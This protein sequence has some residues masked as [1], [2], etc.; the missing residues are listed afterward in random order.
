MNKNIVKHIFWIVIG[1]M[2]CFISACNNDSVSE[3]Q[4]ESFL[5]YYA[6]GIDDNTGTEVIQTPGGYAILG[7]Y[8]NDDDQKDLFVIFTDEFGR[9]KTD[10]PVVIGTD[11][12]DHGYSMISVNDG[13]LITGTSFDATRKLGYLVM[14][15]S[16]GRRVLWERNYSGYQELVFRNAC[17]ARD[18]NLIITGYS[19]NDT[20]DREVILF[21]TSAELDSMWLKLYPLPGRNDVGEAIIEHLGR[22]HILTTSTLVSS[23]R[24]SR[25]RILNTSTDGRGPWQ[26]PLLTDYLS[27]KDIAINDAGNMYILGNLED[28][29]SRVSKI[30]LA[31]LVLT[32][33]NNGITNLGDSA[34]IPDLESLHAAS[35]AAV[36]QNR[37]AI[38]GTQDKQSDHNILYMLVD[39]DNDF[40]PLIRET[41]GSNKGYQS[42]ESIIYTSDQGFA[43]TGSIDLAD[44]KTSML[45][46][47]DSDGELR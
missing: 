12:K 16:D 38:G 34:T 22:Y 10:S 5:K 30:F 33:Q 43:L 46:K 29:V 27:G 15:S 47:L 24:Q 28:P 13:Y 18:G 45:L 41:Y 32:G 35:F 11:L 8:E 2:I 42:S 23:P 4:A 37:L 14:I 1:G 9:Q 3:K 20:G 7:N 25:I 6:V 44:R 17:Q 39:V 40:K 31:E 36:E 26:L 21:K 19:K